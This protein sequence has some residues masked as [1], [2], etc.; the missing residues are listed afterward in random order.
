MKWPPY[1][2]DLHAIQQSQSLTIFLS[3]LLKAKDNQESLSV[4]RLIESFSSDLIH[5]VTRGKTIT[6][7]HFLLGLGLHNLTGQKKPVQIVNRLGHCIE[8]SMACEI[9]T[10]HAEACQKQYAESGVLPIK[11]IDTNHTV[12]T[13]L[14]V[15]NFD[16]NLETQ[17]GHRSLHSTHM[18]AF[19]E[20]SQGSMLENRLCRFPKSRR[21]SVLDSDTRNYDIVVDAKKEPSK[22]GSFLNNA[23]SASMS[24]F[25]VVYL[26]WMVIRM[27]NSNDQLI[28]PFFALKTMLRHIGIPSGA[29]QKTVMTYL[30]PIDENITEFSTINRYS[31][32]VQKLA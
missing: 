16:V 10:S 18:I 19:Q 22:L 24:S 13:F 14:G 32:Y 20:K 28:P 12:N 7:K 23:D 31:P 26:V 9:E 30:T 25:S 17:T 27:L 6:A 29:I 5:G 15:D 11:P 2:G 8:Y 3:H 1:I 4:K 21:R